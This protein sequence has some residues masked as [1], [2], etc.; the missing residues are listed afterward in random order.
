MSSPNALPRWFAVRSSRLIAGVAE[1]VVDVDGHLGLAQKLRAPGYVV[2]LSA[3][4]G[5]PLEP[6]EAVNFVA[7]SLRRG[8]DSARL[9]IGTEHP[10][11]FDI[12]G[13]MCAIGG[14]ASQV[15]PLFPTSG[16]VPA[17][18][19]DLARR[20]SAYAHVGYTGQV[21]A[22]LGPKKTLTEVR[23]LFGL[24][25]LAELVCDP[26][27]P[28]APSRFATAFGSLYAG[29]ET[30]LVRVYD[31]ALRTVEAL[32]AKKTA[33]RAAPLFALWA[34]I[35]RLA[36]VVPEVPLSTFKAREQRH[37]DAFLPV[38]LST[39]AQAIPAAP[40]RRRP[41]ARRPRGYTPASRE[42]AVQKQFQL[43]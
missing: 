18:D 11:L 7:R 28:K 33:T 6:K 10:V 27:A 36:A 4:A 24:S 22:G 5:G 37:R 43:L 30:V 16:T 3:F 20:F 29:D 12:G 26:R 2:A 38:D 19:V 34:E 41:D 8:I 17:G 1:L 35:E 31:E 39:P 14:T 13:D 40:R 15:V 32:L 23:S 42:P 25:L 9:D 21:P